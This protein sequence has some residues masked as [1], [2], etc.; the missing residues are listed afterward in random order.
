MIQIIHACSNNWGEITLQKYN[1]LLFC[2]A[3]FIYS[4]QSTHFS[5]ARVKYTF[6]S[7]NSSQVNWTH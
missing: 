3:A 4:N 5:I 6:N 2:G 1:I 7:C